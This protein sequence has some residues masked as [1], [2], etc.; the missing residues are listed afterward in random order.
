VESRIWIT[1]GAVNL[2]SNRNNPPQSFEEWWLSAMPQFGHTDNFLAFLRNKKIA[3]NQ[4]FIED[5]LGI[6]LL[7]FANREDFFGGL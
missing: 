3:K 4:R 5:I 2:G 1:Y 6:V 7:I